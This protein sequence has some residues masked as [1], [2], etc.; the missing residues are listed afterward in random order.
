MQGD[1]TPTGAFEG[2]VRIGEARDDRAQ[3]R[4]LGVLAYGHRQ[5]SSVGIVRDRI[6]SQTPWR[7][8]FTRFWSD[9]GTRVVCVQRRR[10]L[11]PCARNDR[12]PDPAGAKRVFVVAEVGKPRDRGPERRPGGN[13]R[14]L[15]RVP[16]IPG[17][18]R[19]HPAIGPGLAGNPV[20]HLAHFVHFRPRQLSGTRAERR[21]GA[22]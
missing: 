13:G 10:E 11:N 9:R 16:A 8:R 12:V 22:P 2:V 20:D 4:I 1:L 18:D 14:A 5:Q 19:C 3:V 6:D 7:G 17:S 15:G 21:A